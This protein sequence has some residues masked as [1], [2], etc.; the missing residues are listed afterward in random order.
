MSSPRR[1]QRRSS[2]SLPLSLSLS[3]IFSDSLSPSSSLCLSVSLCVS[4]SRCLIL[5][6]VRE[7]VAEAVEEAKMAAERELVETQQQL[8]RAKGLAAKAQTEASD[9]IREHELAVAQ[10]AASRTEPESDRETDTRRDSQPEP[11]PEPEPSMIP[12]DSQVASPSSLLRAAKLKNRPAVPPPVPA[13]PGREGDSLSLSLS[14][15]FSL[16]LSL[17]LCACVSLT[18]FSLPVPLR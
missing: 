2:R 1:K 14:L 3:G 4:F 8:L 12:R 7:E 10:A 18:V 16:S 13:R 6:Q 15:S 17:S 9:R 11:Q 5:S